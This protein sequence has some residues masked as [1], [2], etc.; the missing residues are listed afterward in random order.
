MKLC[1]YC[2]MKIPAGASICPYCRK[3]QPDDG[4]TALIKFVGTVSWEILKWIFNPKHIFIIITIIAYVLAF[5]YIT[6]K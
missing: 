5:L 6:E 3:K 4:F 2:G 1:S